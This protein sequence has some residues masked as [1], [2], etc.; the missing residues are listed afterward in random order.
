MERDNLNQRAEQIGEISLAHFRH[1]KDKYPL[2]GDVRGLGAMT[3]LEFIQGN[4][5]LTP[6]ADLPPKIVG[7]AYCRGLV[8]RA[9]SHSTA[10]APSCLCRSPTRSWRKA[11]VC[12]GVIAAVALPSTGLYHANDNL[13]RLAAV[14]CG[15]RSIAAGMLP[16]ARRAGVDA[17]RALCQP[18]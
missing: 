7:E 17:R 13:R 11:W 16:D 10:C 8:I 1:W 5:D 18:V 14:L 6:N 2:I 3:A 15:S 12:G 4:G 9:A